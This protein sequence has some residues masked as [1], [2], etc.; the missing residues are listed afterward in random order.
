MIGDI[1]DDVEAGSRVGCRTIL[2]DCGNETQWKMTERTRWLRTADFT[3]D[4]L[5][6]A[7]GIVAAQ[8]VRPAVHPERNPDYRP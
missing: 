7:A 2:I 4:D 6:A 3:V 1:L 5:E 8:G